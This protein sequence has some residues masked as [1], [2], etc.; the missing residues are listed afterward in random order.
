[1]LTVTRL[2]TGYWHIRGKGPC[3]WAQCER[4][5]T[6]K[7]AVR[8]AAFPEASE[9]FIREVLRM[10]E[11]ASGASTPPEPAQEQP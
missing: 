7:E 1:M 5:P 6:T 9:T 2:S 3:N 10:P 4:W 11:Q 8:A